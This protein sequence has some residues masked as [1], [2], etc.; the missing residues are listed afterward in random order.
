MKRDI[1]RIVKQII[2]LQNIR[3]VLDIGAG[4]G[5]DALFCAEQGC[6]VDTVDIKPLDVFNKNIVHYISTI[7]KNIDTLGAYDLIILRSVLHYFSDLSL[8]SKLHKH[9]NENGAVYIFLVYPPKDSGRFTHSVDE[10][11][12]AIAPLKLFSETK[13]GACDE[14]VFKA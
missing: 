4:E 9:L 3:R 12:K 2:E 11:K 1:D 14:L 7:E 13:E 6:V 5:I 10:V 8:L